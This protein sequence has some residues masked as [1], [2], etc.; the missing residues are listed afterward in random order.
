MVYVFIVKLARRGVRRNAAEASSGGGMQRV[1]ATN[2][3]FH[4][5]HLT[6]AIPIL[7]KFERC[8]PSR[9]DRLKSAT[10]DKLG[11]YNSKMITVQDRRIVS[12]KGE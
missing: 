1:W 8:H 5:V 7:A 3:K 12:I 6:V 10:N 2:I 4:T 9:R 11:R